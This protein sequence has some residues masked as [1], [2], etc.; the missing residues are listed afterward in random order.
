MMLVLALTKATLLR[1]DQERKRPDGYRQAMILTGK[2]AGGHGE[3]IHDP[4]LHAMVSA[5]G[6]MTDRLQAGRMH[7]FARSEPDSGAVSVTAGARCVPDRLVNARYSRSLTDSP[8]YRLT[9]VQAD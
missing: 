8:I 7:K 2:Q 3:N 4:E 5:A 1:A 6:K 9:C